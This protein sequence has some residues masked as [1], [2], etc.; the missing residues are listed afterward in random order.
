[1][2]DAWAT[3][4]DELDKAGVTRAE[5]VTQAARY[6]RAAGQAALRLFDAWWTMGQRMK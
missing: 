6:A 2:V 4:D 1:M 3:R 5:L